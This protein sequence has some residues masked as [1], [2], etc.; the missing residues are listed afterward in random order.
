M[1]ITRRSRAEVELFNNYIVAHHSAEVHP[2]IIVPGLQGLDPARRVGGSGQDL[3]F[4]PLLGVP[5]VRP[6]YP[7]P[8]VY[9]LFQ[10][11]GVPGVAIGKPSHRL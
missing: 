1:G 2:H 5:Q 11:G 8:P 10:S 3:E 7:H 6:T 4:A 9:R